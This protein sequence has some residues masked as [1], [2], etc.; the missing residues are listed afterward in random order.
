[1]T[2]DGN[3]WVM[4]HSGHEPI[5]RIHREIVWS[6]GRSGRLGKISPPPGFDPRTVQP[7][8]DPYIDCPGQHKDTIE[9]KY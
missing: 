1:M 2:L 3:E 8:P 4:L 9:L 5:G 7:V 6:Q